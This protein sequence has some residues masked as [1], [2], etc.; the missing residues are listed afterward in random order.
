MPKVTNYTA[1]TTVWYYVSAPNHNNSAVGSV[2]AKV[3]KRNLTVVW[4]Y[5]G[6]TNTGTHTYTYNGG[7]R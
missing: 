3:N 4:D 7:E 5:T 1:G 2:S 6:A